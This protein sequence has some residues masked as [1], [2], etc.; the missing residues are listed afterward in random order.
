MARLLRV[1]CLDGFTGKPKG[2]RTFWGSASL[3]QPRATRDMVNGFQDPILDI[4]LGRRTSWELWDTEQRLRW[5]EHE[6]V[7]LLT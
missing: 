6:K 7:E 4:G 1:P 3:R 2:R 5:L